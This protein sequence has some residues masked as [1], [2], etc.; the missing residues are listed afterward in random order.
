MNL[1]KALLVQQSTIVFLFLSIAW[2]LTAF[3]REKH[4]KTIRELRSDCQKAINFLD[5]NNETQENFFRGEALNI[6]MC[7]G[8]IGAILRT[9]EAYPIVKT[10]MRLN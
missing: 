10:K 9:Y 3:A 2:P 6:G 1:L 4:L 7:L 5:G 8:E